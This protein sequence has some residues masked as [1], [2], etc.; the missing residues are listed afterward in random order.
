MRTISKYE[1]ILT[2]AIAILL[3]FP[4]IFICFSL[5]G[6]SQ[7]NLFYSSAL[8][9]FFSA[10]VGLL[11]SIFI[12]PYY[13][14]KIIEKLN[15]IKR[16]YLSILLFLL[17]Y[18]LLHL[19]DLFA[20]LFEFW[21]DKKENLIVEVLPL[22]IEICALILLSCNILIIILKGNKKVLNTLNKR[23][24]CI[25]FCII[26]FSISIHLVEKRIFIC[27]KGEQTIQNLTIWK[28]PFKKSLNCYIY[29]GKR[30]NLF[31]PI[32]NYILTSNTEI[33]FYTRNDSVFI[34]SHHT[35]TKTIDN[36]CK[37]IN[38]I[39][40]G[41]SILFYE[42]SCEYHHTPDM[43]DSIDIRNLEHERM[44]V[45]EK[46]LQHRFNVALNQ[47]YSQSDSLKL[48]KND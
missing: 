14:E 36:S 12:V 8:I 28:I 48:C 18:F 32:E 19:T 31:P 44:L 20:R 25:C 43:M 30:F 27:F 40:E 34:Y 23:I 4:N 3:F 46:K 33:Y 42:Y 5:F 37:A 17:L 45:K 35:N 29:P 24:I 39:I 10:L 11:S 26:L 1:I 2:I 38:N 22:L 7:D 41:E 21:F 13:R 15:K 47:L 16:F 9:Y 6:I